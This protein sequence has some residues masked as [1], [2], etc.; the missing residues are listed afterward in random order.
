[1]S[2]HLGQQFTTYDADHD[3]ATFNCAARYHGAWWYDACGLADLN[4]IYN[5]TAYG[6][7]VMWVPWRGASY[8]LKA[9]LMSIRPAP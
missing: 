8:S 7:G 5:S 4:G 9:S 3:H 6:E 1:M 2:A